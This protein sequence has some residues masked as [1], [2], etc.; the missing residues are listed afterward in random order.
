MTGNQEIE[1]NLCALFIP[2]KTSPKKRRGFFL[3]IV[4]F[5]NFQRIKGYNK[6]LNETTKNYQAGNQ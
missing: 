5:L 3:F 6:S 1:I 4:T 2:R